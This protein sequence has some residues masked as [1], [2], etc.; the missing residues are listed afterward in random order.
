MIFSSKGVSISQPSWCPTNV[1]CDDFM[2]E[3]VHKKIS[4][5]LKMVEGSDSPYIFSEQYALEKLGFGEDRKSDDKVYDDEF[6]RVFINEFRKVLPF[7]ELARREGKPLSHY[8]KDRERSQ[9]PQ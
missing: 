6:T 4:K 8:M 9:V 1:H 3:K 7:L 5:Y 2:K